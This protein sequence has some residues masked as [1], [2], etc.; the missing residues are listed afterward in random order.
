MRYRL[1]EWKGVARKVGALCAILVALLGGDAAAVG[2]PAGG[3][4]PVPA[5]AAKLPPLKGQPHARIRQLLRKAS[6]RQARVSASAGRNETWTHADGS[7]VLMHLY[8]NVK[9]EKYATANNA[10]V[11]KVPPG[12][13]RLDDRG[14]PVPVN[15]P[16]AHIGVPNPPDLPAVRNRSHGTGAK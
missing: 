8:G 6:F 14:R 3:H 11:H 5:A 7:E 9:E 13:G 2:A 12:G 10:H 4:A 15:S 1:T 16:A